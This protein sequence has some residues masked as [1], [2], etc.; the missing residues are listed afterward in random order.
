MTQS[1][2]EE[3]AEVEMPYQIHWEPRGTLCKFTGFCSVSDVLTAIE[4]IGTDPRFDNLHYEIFD[5]L[6]VQDQDVTISQLENIIALDIAQFYTNP[7]IIYASVA[8]DSRIIELVE[9]YI[10]INHVPVRHMLC[11]TL[12]DARE[13]ID[14]FDT[15]QLPTRHRFYKI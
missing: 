12:V 14:N 3:H 4:K 11:S 5:Y 15:N 2:I 13:W 9:H 8:T 6:D 7:R 1:N 10:N